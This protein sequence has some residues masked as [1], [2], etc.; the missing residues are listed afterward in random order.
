MNLKAVY[1]KK[2]DIV[3]RRIAGETIL[4]PIR[5]NLAD[6]Q[7]IYSLNPVAEFIWEQLDGNQ[8]LQQI[9]DGVTLSFDVAS[10][11]AQKDMI[12]FINQLLD[13]SIIE[14]VK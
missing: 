10:T 8:N 9:R 12:D 1:R 2:E 14:E 11:A 3:T 7:G 6:M 13:Q 4:V 5:S